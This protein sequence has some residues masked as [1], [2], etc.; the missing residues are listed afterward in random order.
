M[1]IKN[2]RG[3]TLIELLAVI[4]LVIIVLTLVI[5][6][7][8]TWFKN[9][10][11]LS[12]QTLNQ[13]KLRFAFEQIVQD[14]E[15]AKEI[16]INPYPSSDQT[17]HLN[18]TKQSGDLVIYG[19]DIETSRLFVDKMDNTIFLVENMNSFI[20]NYENGTYYIEGMI[21][22]IDVRTKR[23]YKMITSAKTITW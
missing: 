2:N 17:H 7:Q 18:I 19:Y 12:E 9:T 1:I 23:P 14:I 13:E 5:S 11:N 6:S 10:N 16:S 22:D 4:V 3:A 20:I 21:G 8:L 15:A